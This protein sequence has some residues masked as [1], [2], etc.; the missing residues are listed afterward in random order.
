MQLLEVREEA[1]ESDLYEDFEE[2]LMAQGED[3][4]AGADE[5]LQSSAIS[6]NFKDLEFSK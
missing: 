2:S 1:S 3:K 6:G 4:V 5:C